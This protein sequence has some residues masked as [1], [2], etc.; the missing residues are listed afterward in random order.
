MITLHSCN[1]LLFSLNPTAT[2]LNTYTSI[3]LLLVHLKQQD[4]SKHAG[5]ICVEI[6]YVICAIYVLKLVQKLKTVQSCT[7]I[8]TLT[9]S[10]LFRV[11]CVLLL[12]VSATCDLWY[13]T[14][15]NYTESCVRVCSV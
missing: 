6:L 5:D 4:S 7:S 1:A 13:N 14:C 12:F 10:M 11:L 3:S 8:S 15:H 9:V 2:S